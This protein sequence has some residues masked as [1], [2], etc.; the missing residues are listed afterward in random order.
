MT[1]PFFNGPPSPEELQRQLSEML[2]QH[3]QSA[4]EPKPAEADS[5]APP[6]EPKREPTADLFMF[7]YKP[8]EVKEHLDRFVI[9]QD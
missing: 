5:P 3:L 9:K 8:R 4:R 6:E 2:R 1:K 7:D